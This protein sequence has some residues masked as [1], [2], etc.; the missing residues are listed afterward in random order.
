MTADYSRREKISR[1][2]LTTTDEND[3]KA[4]LARLSVNLVRSLCGDEANKSGILRG[5]T[6]S[7][8]AASMQ[9]KVLEGYGLYYDAGSGEPDS[10][11]RVI[12]VPEAGVTVTLDVGD[13]NPRWDLIEIQ[14][15][16]V[17]GTPE[18]IDFWDPVLG[19]FTSSPASPLKVASPSV[20]VVKG[21][22][23]AAAKLP[24]G[25]AGWMPL[26][27]QYVPGSAITLSADQTLHCRPI[28]RPQGDIFD[29][30]N[31]IPT[32]PRRNTVTGG[33]INVASDGAD[34]TCANALEGYFN[35][36]HT[37][38]RV[39]RGATVALDYACYDGGGLPAT[40]RPLYFY[41]V[42]PPL[43]DGTGMDLA[44]REFYIY[45][46]TII[47]GGY[48][49]GYSGCVVIASPT[50]PTLS[51]QGERSGTATFDTHPT[52]GTWPAVST[53]RPDWYY[54][55]AAYYDNGT[56]LVIQDVDGDRVVNDR[57][58][59]EDLA[60]LFPIVGATLIAACT[61]IAGDPPI[62]YPETAFD[63]IMRVGSNFPFS[64]DTCVSFYDA[65][66]DAALSGTA[67]STTARLSDLSGVLAN[68]TASQEFLI[69]P[70]LFG[71]SSYIYVDF[72][73][74]SA[75]APTEVRCESYRDIV[76]ALR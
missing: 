28:L 30:R 62:R 26:A 59:G 39:N 18:V 58:P 2:R 61:N 65:R 21:T 60:A 53:N 45:D 20:Q 51:A 22:P 37:P 34:G 66:R 54:L 29:P 41:A 36:S 38:F 52:F 33:G 70:V 56:G 19:T 10:R 44:P 71:S 13:P 43:P 64:G 49:D 72:A 42:P 4:Y 74:S 50:G 25:T 48:Y 32:I 15:A 35:L 76:L 46:D 68:T 75:A 40:D 1:Q 57:K 27:Y 16:S 24:T 14:P 55:G 63:V 23:S 6:A 11:Y 69:K 67:G 5:C 3:S 12:E 9:V 73:D 7:V 47:T 31:V 17:N 8:V